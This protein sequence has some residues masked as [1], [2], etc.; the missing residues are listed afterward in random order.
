M[1]RP[2]QAMQCGG[3]KS[4]AAVMTRSVRPCTMQLSRR[5]RGNV[6]GLKHAID[7]VVLSRRVVSKRRDRRRRIICG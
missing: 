1:H 2:V 4:G 6:Y 5:L 3:G 7:N